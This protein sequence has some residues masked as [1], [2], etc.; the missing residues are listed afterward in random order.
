MP[1]AHANISAEK[2]IENASSRQDPLAPAP[3]LPGSHSLAI[4]KDD[5]QAR[6]S[7]L[8]QHRQGIQAKIAKIQEKRRDTADQEK[9]LGL[10][11]K[12]QVF[13]QQLNVIAEEQADLDLER[14]RLDQLSKVDEVESA[15]AQRGGTQ[16]AGALV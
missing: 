2:S 9:R 14:E 1:D 6:Q 7:K 8:D 3:E 4:S 15:L 5:W 12:I 16:E 11:E 13:E 10:R